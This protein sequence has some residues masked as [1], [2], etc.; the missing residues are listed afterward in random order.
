MAQVDEVVVGDVTD[1]EDRE[2][3]VVEDEHVADRESAIGDVG[4]VQDT[5]VMQFRRRILAEEDQHPLLDEGRHHLPDLGD[6]GRVAGG[7]GGSGH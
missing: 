6:S 7:S 3:V 4:P 5:H 1:C 2:L